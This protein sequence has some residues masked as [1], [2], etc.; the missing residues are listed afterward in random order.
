MAGP[1]TGRRALEERFDDVCAAGRVVQTAGCRARSGRGPLCRGLE[2]G[3]GELA[4]FPNLRVIFNLGAGVDALM[5]DSQPARR[6][7]GARRGADLTERMTEYVVLHA[8]MHHRQELYL[9]ASSAKNAGRRNRNGRRTR[10]R[11]AS[12]GWARSGPMPPGCSR[13]LGFRVVGL[14]PEPRGSTA[15][16]ASRASSSSTHSCGR[17]T[18]WSACCR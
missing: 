13:Q 8:L 16:N 2:A 12:W 5:A 7:A 17:P 14:E 10:S 11:S 3:P 1:K 9:R 6:A 15:S 4:T 18:S